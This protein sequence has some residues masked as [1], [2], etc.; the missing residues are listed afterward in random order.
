VRALQAVDAVPR[1]LFMM[2]EELA[3]CHVGAMLRERPGR[4]YCARCLGRLLDTAAWTKREARRAIAG[5]FRKPIGLKTTL[6]YRR[7]PCRDCGQ[8]SGA[9]LGAA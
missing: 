9:R 1:T 6:R 4:F 7:N 2:G 5:L 8:A 3:R